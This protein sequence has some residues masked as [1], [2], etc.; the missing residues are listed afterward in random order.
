MVDR[1][2][3]QVSI[4][5][6]HPD[7]DAEAIKSLIKGNEFFKDWWHH[8]PGV[9]LVTATADAGAVAAEF[10]KATKD[11]KLLVMAVDPA[12]SDGWLPDHSWSWIRRREAEHANG[13]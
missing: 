10:R 4:D 1:S 13:P 2:M 11:A 7:Y 3:F 12:R 6:R 9:F 5:I 8:L